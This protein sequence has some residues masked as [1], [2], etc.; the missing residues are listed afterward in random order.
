[1]G[2]AQRGR[3]VH[4]PRWQVVLAD[5]VSA[6]NPHPTPHRVWPT[7]PPHQCSTRRENHHRGAH[8]HLSLAETHNHSFNPHC[9]PRCTTEPAPSSSWWLWQ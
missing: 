7:P 2:K 4:C 5:T 9:P 1:M 8:S 3:F 6:A